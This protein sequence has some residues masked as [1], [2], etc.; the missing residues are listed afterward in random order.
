PR[1]KGRSLQAETGVRESAN[2]EGDDHPGEGIEAGERRDHDARI[3]EARL[4]QAAW[5]E[6]MPKITDL[7]RAADAGERPRKRHHGH[8]LSPS[9][10]A[11]VVGRRPRVADDPGLETK[12]GPRV[13]Q[14]QCGGRDHPV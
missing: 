7:A 3:A 12:S 4:L 13:D 6:N 5:I 11:G 8:D 9:P 1:R 14:P 2:A 10:D